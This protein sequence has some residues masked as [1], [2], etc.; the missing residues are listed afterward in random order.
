MED[1]KIISSNIDITDTIDLGAYS[2]AKSTSILGPGFETITIDTSTMNYASSIYTSSGTSSAT[3]SWP[4]SYN[5]GL[6]GTNEPRINITADGI[7]M[8]EGTDITIGDKSLTAAIEKIEERLAILRPN[9]ELENRW[10]QLKDLRQQYIEL[11]KELN[12]SARYKR[13]KIIDIKKH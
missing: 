2:A 9:E 12:N 6:S 1:D 13:I 3:Y 7:K 10:Q 8:P 4:N 11:E 5:Y